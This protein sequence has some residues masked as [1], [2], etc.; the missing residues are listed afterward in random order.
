MFIKEQVLENL[1]IIECFIKK[2]SSVIIKIII[3]IK[4]F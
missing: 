1:F 2:K 4:L 3:A